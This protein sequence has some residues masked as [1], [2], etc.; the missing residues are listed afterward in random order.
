M[1]MIAA[2]VEPVDW[3]AFDLQNCEEVGRTESRINEV[4]DYNVLED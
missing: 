4:S 3:K 1:W 2:D